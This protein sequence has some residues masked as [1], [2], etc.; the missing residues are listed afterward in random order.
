MPELGPVFYLVPILT[1]V[2]M[3]EREFGNCYASAINIRPSSKDRLV[4][5]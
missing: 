3:K 2:T 1:I 5:T 4:A